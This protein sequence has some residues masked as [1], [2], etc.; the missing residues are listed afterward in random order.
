MKNVARNKTTINNTKSYQLAKQKKIETDLK[1]LQ[2][3]QQLNSATKL[4]CAE[5]FYLSAS[6]E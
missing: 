1:T 4:L 5:L 2:A 3:L 6:H